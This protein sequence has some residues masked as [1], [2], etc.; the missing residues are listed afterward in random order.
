MAGK[1]KNL[2][3]EQ[4][5]SYRFG[6]VTSRVGAVLA[7]T[8]ATRHELTMPAWRS[9]AVIARHGPLSAGELGEK[10]SSDPYRVVRAIDLLVKRG[11][12]TRN[13]D[14]ADRRRA[15]LELTAAGRKTYE[16]IEKSAVAVEGFLREGLTAQEV[17]DLLRILTKI[18]AQVEAMAAAQW[19]LSVPD[20]PRLR[21]PQ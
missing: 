18:D 15:Y 13:L 4:W 11:L 2:L 14:P 8:Y 21:S 12:I 7:S 1:K 20:K 16:E 9:L 3:L 10:T 17:Q 5:I 6:M 19:D